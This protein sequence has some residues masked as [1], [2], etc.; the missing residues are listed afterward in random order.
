MTQFILSS[1]TRSS[2]S[3]RSPSSHWLMQ[4]RR[5]TV[6]HPFGTS[7]PSLASPTSCPLPALRQQAPRRGRSWPSRARPLPRT[8]VVA[9]APPAALAQR[10]HLIRVE[11]R[12]RGCAV[13][14]GDGLAHRSAAAASIS[15]CSSGPLDRALLARPRRPSTSAVRQGL[16]IPRAEHRIGPTADI[17]NPHPRTTSSL[18]PGGGCP[19]RVPNSVVSSRLLLFCAYSRIAKDARIARTY[20]ARRDS[21][22]AR[23]S[24]SVHRQGHLWFRTAPT[25]ARSH[26]FGLLFR[27]WDALLDDCRGQPSSKTYLSP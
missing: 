20:P 27:T 7:M 21:R 25:L 16:R 15:I 1:C 2:S 3:Q 12:R 24:C 11:Q 18:V 4:L 17:R 26:P 5:E 10:H 8:D 13:R 14:H 6:E 19:L 23:S 22:G 9:I